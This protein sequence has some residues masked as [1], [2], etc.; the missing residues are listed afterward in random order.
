MPKTIFGTT[1]KSNF[2]LN[3]K[4]ETLQKWIHGVLACC[5]II[6]LIGAAVLTLLAKINY[7]S[8][9]ILYATGFTCVLFFLIVMLKKDMLFK[10]NRSYLLIIALALTAVISYYGTL[11]KSADYIKVALLG[12]LGRYEGLLAVLSYLG[13]FLLATAVS[14]ESTVERLFDLLVGAGTVEAFVALLQHLPFDFNTSDYRDLPTIAY[15]NVFLSSGLTGSPI[16]YG[17]ITTLTGAVAVVGAVY[18]ASKRRAKLYAAAAVFI[19]L[20]GMF[21]CSVVPLIGEAAVILT[22]LI[23]EAVNSGKFG[24]VK[25][26]GKFL[27]TSL[28]RAG[29][30]VAGLILTFVIVLFTQGFYFRDRPIA[31]YDSFYRLF[32]TNTMTLTDHGKGNIPYT[33][34]FW[35]EQWGFALETANAVPV[36]G[37][38]PDCL[39]FARGQEANYNDKC[40]N[41]FLYIAATRGYISLAAYA[42]LIISTIVVLCKRMKQFFGDKTKWYIPCMMAAV[43]GYV[44]QSCFNASSITTAPF[45]W[46]MLGMVWATRLGKSEKDS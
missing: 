9:A 21:T 35:K 28:K 34:E 42:A 32:I 22:V 44:V 7:F 36:T 41:E 10:D 37:V 45:F 31:F 24:G 46:L 8:A 27:N 5:I 26:D 20:T 39:A 40:Y 1:E 29:A 3:M 18:S 17:A 6:P 25:F 14:K 12:N 16:F 4:S 2:I 13:I 30:M 23:I 15:E 11:S 38:G 19:F 33:V 43:I